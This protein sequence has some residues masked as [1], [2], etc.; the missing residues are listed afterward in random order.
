MFCFI[1]VSKILFP[2]PLVFETSLELGQS[3]V[4]NHYTMEPNCYYFA[5]LRLLRFATRTQLMTLFTMVG[6]EPTI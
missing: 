2:A 3:S 1:K 5:P 4:Q 6:F